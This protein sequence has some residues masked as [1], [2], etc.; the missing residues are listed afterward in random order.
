M[1][2]YLVRTDK[3]IRLDEILH[4]HGIHHYTVK[5]LRKHGGLIDADNFR[6]KLGERINELDTNSLYTDEEKEIAWGI[7]MSALLKLKEE[8]IVEANNGNNN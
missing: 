8:T 5:R 4:L 3:P 1:A 2:E 7:F 6:K